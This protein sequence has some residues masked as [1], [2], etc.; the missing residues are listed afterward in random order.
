MV[1]R[2]ITR[3]TVAGIALLAAE[4]AYAVLRPS[5]DM[6]Q[7]DPSGRF[8][9]VDD[10]LL[11]VAVL[12]DSTVTGPGVGSAENTWA[13]TTARRLA[14]D[15]YQVELESFAVSGSRARD[16]VE[17]QLGPTL[18]WDADMTW[19][20]VGANDVLKGTPISEFREHLDA[21]VD[22]LSAAGSPVILSGVGDLGTI[23]RLMPPLRGLITRRS[24][25]FDRIHREVAEKYGA[26]VVDQRSDP[27]RLWL[28]DREL[29]AD[30][31]F[32]MSAK[33]HGR[34]ADILWL[35][36]ESVLGTADAA[37]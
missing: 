12:G 2:L 5:P 1:G 29:W 27:R 6:V 19:V 26:I 31:L 37:V 25:L 14:R 13:Q 9:D 21:L 35:H 28:K 36:I 24:L 18:A 30:D 34:H 22:G 4:L 23:P 10:P 3:G 33:G 17:G 32:H 7:F 16:L 15:G 20:S 8:G 11:K